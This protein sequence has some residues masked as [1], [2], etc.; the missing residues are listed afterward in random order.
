MSPAEADRGMATSAFAWRGLSLG[1]RTQPR[2]DTCRRGGFEA[3][4]GSPYPVQP[5]L[6]LGMVCH[7][8]GTKRT[9][10][11]G[12]RGAPAAG[13]RREGPGARGHATG[14]PQHP[15]GRLQA[16]TLAQPGRHAARR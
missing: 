6:D 5:V 12:P 4:T 9:T 14:N 7:R 11:P 10:R 15:T 2:G 16:R 8:L 3:A 1:S 13:R